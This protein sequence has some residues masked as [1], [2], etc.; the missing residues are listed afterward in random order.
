M[1]NLQFWIRC[2]K[3]VKQLNYVDLLQCLTINGAEHYYISLDFRF[4]SFCWFAWKTQAFL[5]KV[6]L[7]ITVFHLID[8]DWKIVVFWNIFMFIISNNE[9]H[10]I[11]MSFFFQF[12]W[13][14]YSKSLKSKNLR[15]SIKIIRFGH[16]DSKFWN[17]L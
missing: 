14:E 15:S 6:F 12:S 11:A 10:W 13:N 7:I 17:I 5:N 9:G 3:N 2:T 16:F 1:F 4:T 8:S